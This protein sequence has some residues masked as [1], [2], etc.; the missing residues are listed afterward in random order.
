MWQKNIATDAEKH[1][2]FSQELRNS[3]EQLSN[4]IFWNMFCFQTFK[5]DKFS[6]GKAEED[7]VFNAKEKIEEK[8]VR[9]FSEKAQQLWTIIEWQNNKLRGKPNILKDIIS[10]TCND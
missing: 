9:I 5:L 1:A 7:V 8:S 2:L 3:S 10:Q 6:I 4:G